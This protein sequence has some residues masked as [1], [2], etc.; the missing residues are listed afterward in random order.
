MNEESNLSEEFNQIVQRFE[1]MM[2]DN[3]SYYFDREELE[4]LIFYYSDQ[5]LFQQALSVVEHAKSLF[6]NQPG[7]QIREAE[8]YTSMGQLHKALGILK[9]TTPFAED[10]LD[11]LMASAVS[12]SQLHEHERAIAFLEQALELSDSENFDDIALEL[13]LEYQNANKTDKAIALLKKVIIHRP[14][15]ETLLYE[16]AYCYE[17]TGRLAEALEF[18]TSLTDE[19]PMSF[20][21]WYCLGNIQQ[22][23]ELLNESVESYDFSLALMPD[24]VPAIINKAQAQFKLKQ[25][26][27]AIETL[28]SSFH[29]EP[30]DATTYCHLGECYEKLDEVWVAQEYYLK[31]IEL[32]ERC[33]DAYLGMAVVLDYQ[34][35]S[36]E[37]LKF[38]EIAFG[39]DGQNEEYLTVLIKLLAKNEFTEDAIQKANELILL[40]PH[41]E[42]S[43]V[44]MADIHYQMSAI[45]NG[46]QYLEQGLQL[47]PDSTMIA[48]RKLLYLVGLKRWNEAEQWLELIFDHEQLEEINEIESMDPT[49]CEWIPYAMKKKYH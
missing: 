44:V 16:M 6:P 21:T 29:L 41:D 30:P 37:A 27:T 45:S 32:D 47:I 23:L 34:S 24:F 43:W 5:F 12:Y 28:Q 39:F 26:T 42:E 48:Y 11:W 38:A 7:I 17:T 35:K 8:I 1:Q 20:P 10:Q 25:Y 31:A 3:A 14:E 22:Q 15:S 9:K 19:K 40:R 4:E 18:F 2:R 33:S 46:L 13:A 36:K 49:I